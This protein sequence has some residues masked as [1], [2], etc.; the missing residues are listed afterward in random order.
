MNDLLIGT[1]R[2][3][4]ERELAELIHT[5]V[6]SKNFLNTGETIEA[7]ITVVQTKPVV[8]VLEGYKGRL[9]KGQTLLSDLLQGHVR[10]TN[11]LIAQGFSTVDQICHKSKDD[12]LRLRNITRSHLN[13]LHEALNSIGFKVDWHSGA[14]AE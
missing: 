5:W 6:K 3:A 1:E 2:I 10:L 14:P 7:T 4:L 9:D 8:A 11:T 13:I 12:I